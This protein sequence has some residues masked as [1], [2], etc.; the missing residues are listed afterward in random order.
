M[1]SHSGAAES[2]D[3]VL[4]RLTSYL[5]NRRPNPTTKFTLE[6]DF[7]CCART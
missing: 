4:S 5:G 2:P 6:S 3:F 1:R 7:E